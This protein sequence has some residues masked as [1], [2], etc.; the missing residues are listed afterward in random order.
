MDPV[1]YG[2]AVESWKGHYDK[3]MDHLYANEKLI[4]MP[5]FIIGDENF[6]NIDPSYFKGELFRGFAELERNDYKNI[7]RLLEKAIILT[8]IGENN[9]NLLFGSIE[10]LSQVADAIPVLGK[11]LQVGVH[12]HGDGVGMKRYKTNTKLNEKL[13]NFRKKYWDFTAPEQDN[14]HPVKDDGHGKPYVERLKRDLAAGPP[15]R[16]ASIIADE[17]YRHWGT[18]P[19]NEKEFYDIV[20]QGKAEREAQ[21]ESAV[22]MDI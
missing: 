18:H 2:R 6:K 13:T 11:V 20:K 9:E 14:T 22:R 10:D 17:L 16:I 3:I 5:A 21:E 19:R 12:Y 8:E 4:L 7:W 1:I 15:V